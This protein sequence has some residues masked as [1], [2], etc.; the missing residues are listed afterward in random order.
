MHF[1]AAGWDSCEYQIVDNGFVDDSHCAPGQLTF[2]DD[3]S[4]FTYGT[5]VQGYTM[6][7]MDKTCTTELT[8]VYNGAVNAQLGGPEGPG[9]GYCY[10]SEDGQCGGF[11]NCAPGWDYYM[12]LGVPAANCQP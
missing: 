10:Y 3:D 11:D 5:Q 1:P 2:K 8:V 6:I 9:Y 12:Y 4:Q 7:F